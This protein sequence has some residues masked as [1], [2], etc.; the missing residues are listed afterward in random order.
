MLAPLAPLATL[1]GVWL[2]HRVRQKLFYQITYG[3]VFVVAIKLLYD[4]ALLLLA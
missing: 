1:A 3:C 4:S 2:V